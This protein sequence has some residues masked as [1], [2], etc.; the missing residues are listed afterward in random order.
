VSSAGHAVGGAGRPREARV[1]QAILSA[2]LRLL[3]ERGYQQMSLDAVAAAA[4]V[5]KPSIYRRYPSKAALVVAAIGGL[6]PPEQQALPDATREALTLMTR[7]TAVALADP[8]GMTVLGTLIAE[9]QREPE[10]AEALRTHVFRPAIAAL[11]RV[12]MRGVK[13]G[14]IRSDVAPMAV[15]D[16][17][18][19]SLLA[20][21]ALGEPA[22]E[23]WL[24]AILE[25]CWHGMAAG[26]PADGAGTH[27][28]RPR[29]SR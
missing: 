24:S 27:L 8:G 1:D 14:E 28:T 5:G 3:R 23:P 11:E 15:I 18:F 4:R 13:R 16:M 10:L 17:L 19:G 22:D 20:R 6:G 26:R 21:A 12:I 25:T 29:A 7:R 9:R 2:T